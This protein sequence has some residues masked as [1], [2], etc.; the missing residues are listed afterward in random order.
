MERED[1]FPIFF[2]TIKKYYLEVFKEEIEIDFSD[3]KECNLIIRPFL[4]SATAPTISS[5]A[6]SFFYSEWNVRNSIIKYWVTKFGVFFLTHS[7]K[8]FSLFTFR[9]TPEDAVT[10]NLVIAPNNRSIRFFDYGAGTVGC[11]IKEGFTKKYFTNQLEFRKKYQYPFMLPMIKWGADWFV[12]PIL[13]GHPL[14]RVTNEKIYQKGIADALDGVAQLAADTLEY[15]DAR[16]YAAELLLKITTLA[17][18]AVTEKKITQAVTTIRIAEEA[19]ECIQK[20]IYIVP[21]CM[22]HGDFQ[23]GNIWIDNNE[24][25]WLYDWETAGRRSVWYDSAV[26]C[27]SLRREY[28]WQSLAEAKDPSE[29]LSCDTKKQYTSE[30]FRSIKHLILLEDIIFYLEDM[31]ELPEDWGASIYDSFISRIEKITI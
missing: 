9:M 2:R 7:G 18:K 26:L 30:E 19:V 31:L 10:N 25:T 1:F 28:G 27:Y 22:S 24:K 23:G 12:E 29:L 14:A 8:A 11:M 15:V 21:T 6:R 16:T 4:S 5:K 17:K 20:C 13:S 3:K